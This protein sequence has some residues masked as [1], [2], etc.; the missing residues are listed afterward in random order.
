MQTPQSAASSS[1]PVHA[2]IHALLRAEA[3][4][5][6]RIGELLDALPEAER[7]AA[8]RSLSGREQARLWRAVDGARPLRLIDLVPASVPALTP[9]RHYGKNSLPMFSLFE[10]RFYRAADQDPSAPR[11]LCGANFQ[12]VSPLT[13]PGYF[14]VHAHPTRDELDVDYRSVPSVA[15]AGWPALATNDRGRGKLVFGFMV[16]TLRRVSEHVTIGSAARH[17]KD[18]KSYFVLC[19]EETR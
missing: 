19:R 14:V 13:G 9:V 18:I 2:D 17:G 15:P 12:L 4:D 10:K 6:R 16:D 3:P 5:A 1:Q 8:V 7:I 11:E